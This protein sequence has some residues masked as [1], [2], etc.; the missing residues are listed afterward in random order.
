MVLGIECSNDN[1][2]V[3]P[4]LQSKPPSEHLQPL[5]PGGHQLLHRRRRLCGRGRRLALPG[6]PQQATGV[7][8]DIRKRTNS[9]AGVLA[10]HTHPSPPPV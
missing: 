7:H 5:Q 10:P 3:F 2:S 6:A 8:G 1:L 9:S 4:V